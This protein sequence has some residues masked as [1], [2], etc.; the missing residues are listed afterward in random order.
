[1]DINTIIKSE[2][3]K[4]LRLKYDIDFH[5]FEIQQTRKD[6]EGDITVV[7]FPLIKLLKKNPVCLYAWVCK[8]C[9]QRVMNLVLAKA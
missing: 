8:F 1:M 5:D 7:I 2:F 3:S 6:F 4:Y 9:F